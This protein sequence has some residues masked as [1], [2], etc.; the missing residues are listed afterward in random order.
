MLQGKD[1]VVFKRE[2]SSQINTAAYYIGKSIA[3][4]PT[5]ILAPLFFTL[6]YYAFL[7]PVDVPMWNYFLLYFSVGS[8]NWTHSVTLFSKQIYFV[9]AGLSYF[10]SILFAQHLS[11]LVGVLCVLIFMMFSGTNPTL[12]Q[13]K[14]NVLG[15]K[16]LF[17]PSY[18][19]LFRWTNELYYLMQVE[20]YHPRPETLSLYSYSMDD[21]G[22][23]ITMIVLLGVTFRILAYLAIVKQ[24]E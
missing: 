2:S 14:H 1:K 5:V 17:F 18:G 22:M 6:C 15:P 12:D 16:I 24:E 3:H 20:P 21:F 11:N 9:C 10:I 19:S 13:L 4:L 23:C 7:R 8:F